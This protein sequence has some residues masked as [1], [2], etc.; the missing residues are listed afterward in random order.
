VAE[1]FQTFDQVTPESF[2]FHAVEVIPAQISVLQM[3]FEQVVDDH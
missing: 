1:G 3:V 2:G